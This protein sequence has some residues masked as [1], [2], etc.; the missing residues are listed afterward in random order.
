M[1][2]DHVAQTYRNIA[3]TGAS[4]G[5]GAALAR[6]LAQPGVKLFLTG[7]R[8]EA[9]DHIAQACRAKGATVQTATVD[10][11][12]RNAIQ[13]WARNISDAAPIDLAILCAGIFGGSRSQGDLEPLSEAVRIID[14][15]LTGSLLPASILAE[16]MKARG[17]GRIV[18]ISSLAALM[19]Q[20]DSA[21][22]SASKA[23]LSAY[24][25]ALRAL[26]A[27]SGVQ[28]SLIH[29]GHVQTRQTR[30]QIGRLPLVLPP[31]Q[32]ADIIVRALERGL[33]E[34]N[35]P[36]RLYWLI[37]ANN[38]LPL[39]LQILA[40]RSFRYHVADSDPES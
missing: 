24:A 26:L 37:R 15:N 8:L 36:K 39:W 34:I 40:N 10:A 18:F 6:R 9:L 14:T 31:D 2:G 38:L 33:A 27:P 12:D 1:K 25:K 23:G 28:V 29:P 4:A 35:F 5:I 20:A 19:P 16:N 32:A 22:Y 30:Q 13:S 17:A 3:I 11:T 21:A 7:R